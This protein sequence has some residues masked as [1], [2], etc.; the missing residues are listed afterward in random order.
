MNHSNVCTVS[1]L[2]PPD[3]IQTYLF[4]WYFI[5]EKWH[6]LYS[7]SKIC[8]NPIWTSTKCIFLEDAIVY[9][10][11]SL[12][13]LYDLFCFCLSER[14]L[15]QRKLMRGC[16]IFKDLIKNWFCQLSI[17][18][19]KHALFDMDIN[20]S[21]LDIAIFQVLFVIS[22]ETLCY[23]NRLLTCPYKKWRLN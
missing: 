21:K 23:H 18:S 17:M 6:A 16:W 20:I 15:Y 3:V 12:W 13:P 9:Y 14:F 2:L 22:L 19:W 1:A 4:V 10:R 11:L 8:F 5:R 7:A